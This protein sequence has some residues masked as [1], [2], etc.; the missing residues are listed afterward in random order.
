MSLINFLINDII[1]KDLTFGFDF[2][3]NCFFRSK[4]F[5]Y[6]IFGFFYLVYNLVKDLGF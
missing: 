2:D 1:G 3:F 4:F 6:L 5:N